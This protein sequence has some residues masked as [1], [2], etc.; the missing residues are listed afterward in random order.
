MQVQR[1]MT[2]ESNEYLHEH[3]AERIINK[4]PYSAGYPASALGVFHRP[5]MMSQFQGDWGGK[6]VLAGHWM[7]D[8]IG[9][10][11]P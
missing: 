8:H 5:R 3:N 4:I 7:H 10:V 9:L 2:T 1:W 6:W 11:D